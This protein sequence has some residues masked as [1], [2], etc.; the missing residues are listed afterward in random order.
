MKTGTR[1][2]A[3][4]NSKKHKLLRSTLCALLM[5][6]SFPAEAQ[7]AKK[8]PLIGYL[9]GSSFSIGKS[10]IDAFRQGLHELGYVEGKNILLEYR[11]A[12]AKFDRLPALAAEL[13]SLKADV[14]VTAGTQPTLAVKQASS[15]IP[16][17]V[18]SAGDLVG[19]G[20]VASLARPGGN[21][22]GSTNIDP[23]LSAKRLELLKETIPKLSRVAILYHGGPGGDEDELQETQAAAKRSKVQ[24]QSYRVQNPS[25]FE[26]VYGTMT[27]ERADALII[28]HGN[29]TSFHRR[30]LVDLATKKRLP[31]MC[32]QPAWS[33]DGGLISY[34]HDRRHQYRRAAYFVDKILKGAKPADLPV[35]QPMKFEFVINLKT[36]KRI[37]LTIPP[38]VLVRADKVIK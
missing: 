20:L 25:E 9:G 8:V 23:D 2:A 10:N 11:W 28:F 14:I 38:N 30:Q 29:F 12:D 6:L 36:A 35:E 16:I 1:H 17:V 15:T 19:T 13:V 33:E 37:G 7:Q 34:G 18:G 27:K 22:T 31:T 24:V 4:G 32:G 3:T 5:A 26:R 21:V